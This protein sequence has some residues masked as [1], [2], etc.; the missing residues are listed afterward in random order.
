VLDIYTNLQKKGIVMIPF[1]STKVN[2]VEKTY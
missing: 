1:F 2:F